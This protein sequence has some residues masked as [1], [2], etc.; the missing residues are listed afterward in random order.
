MTDPFQ[1]LRVFLNDRADTID[2]ERSD[3]DLPSPNDWMTAAA[4]LEQA[5]RRPGEGAAR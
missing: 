3:L 2:G 4:L 1:E 5:L